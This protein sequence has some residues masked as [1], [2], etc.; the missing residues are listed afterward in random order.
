MERQKSPIVL[1]NRQR[2]VQG[3]TTDN[4]TRHLRG[5]GPAEVVQRFR[6]RVL[7]QVACRE[8]GIHPGHVDRV[9]VVVDVPEGHKVV[10]IFRY[11]LPDHVGLVALNCRVVEL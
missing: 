2:N 4:R 7:K 5:R 9:E 6:A 1:T 11:Q 10:S 8:F 3:P